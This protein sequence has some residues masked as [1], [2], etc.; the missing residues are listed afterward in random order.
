MEVKTFM[1]PNELILDIACNQ[2]LLPQHARTR[3][4][5]GE[6]YAA[7]PEDKKEILRNLKS[8]DTFNVNKDVVRYLIEDAQLQWNRRHR[9]NR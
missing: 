2:T 6:A 7:L 1:T 5:P 4:K 3:G 8:A 9:Y